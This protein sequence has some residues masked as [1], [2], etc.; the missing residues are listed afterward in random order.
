MMQKCSTWNK[1]VCVLAV[2]TLGMAASGFAQE[3]SVFEK[4]VRIKAGD[5]FIKVDRG[6]SAPY[7]YDF[8]KDG[9]LDLLVGEF[10]SVPYVPPPTPRG[11]A[12]G[13]LRIYKN[14]GTNEAPKYDGF[15]NLMGG[16]VPL[17]IPAT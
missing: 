7:L 15:K 13:R 1:W 11:Y 12:Q 10:G 17:S 8:D 2:L 16:G 3:E 9:K 14:V 4:P 6:H 5:E